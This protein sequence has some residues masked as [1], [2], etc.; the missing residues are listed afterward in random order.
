VKGPEK[1][2]IDRLWGKKKKKKKNPIR[3]LSAR[4]GIELD[5]PLLPPPHPSNDVELR[6]DLWCWWGMALID[7]QTNILRQKTAV[8]QAS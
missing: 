7:S 2:E 6:G 1:E 5:Y 3:I 4:V 8:D